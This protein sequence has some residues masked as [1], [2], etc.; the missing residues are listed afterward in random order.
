M[1]MAMQQ[2]PR[3]FK[4]G[5]TE[6]PDP[7]PGQSLDQA[8]RVLSRQFPQFRQSRLYEED[9]VLENGKLVYTLLIAPP[10][11]NG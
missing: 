4:L 10:K 2:L 9:A 8:V 3:V 7:V 11:V 1:T 5:A 6:L